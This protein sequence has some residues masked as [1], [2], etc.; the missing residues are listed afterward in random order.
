M[1][2]VAISTLFKDATAEA[3]YCQKQHTAKVS[4]P[5][6]PFLILQSQ[7]AMYFIGISSDRPTQVYNWKVKFECIFLCLTAKFMKN[8]DRFMASIIKLLC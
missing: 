5:L 6:K 2:D 1:T 3:F 4:I 7:T 8:V